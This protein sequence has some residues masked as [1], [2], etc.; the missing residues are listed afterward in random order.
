MISSTNT[1]ISQMD[2]LTEICLKKR[3]HVEYKK[4]LRTIDDMKYMATDQPLPSG[5]ISALRS[6]QGPALIAEVKKASPSK[7]IIR[8][9]FD[10]IKIAQEYQKAGAPC[11]SVLTDEP[12]FQGCDGY[13]VSI[14]KAVNIPVLRKDFMID[15][16]QIYESR[17]LGADCILLIMAALED[18]EA[19]ELYEIARELRMDILVEVHNLEELERSKKLDPMMIG[20]NNRNLKTLDVDVK[21]SHDLLRY[22]PKNCFKVS[23]SGLADNE[24][25][26]SLHSVGYNAFLVGESLMRQE[27]IAEAVK[28]L[29]GK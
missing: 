14:K 29:I 3:E 1:K 6:A 15:P 7:G 23:E 26:K 21:T 20:V 10:P 4:T 12:Y 17:T 25:I 11:L 13:M 22:M 2:T 16:Y 24:T 28:Q 18:S 9:D 27:N 5:F 8:H 19:T